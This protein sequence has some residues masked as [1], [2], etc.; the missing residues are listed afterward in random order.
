MS[1]EVFFS[2]ERPLHALPDA[3]QVRAAT[4]QG[5]P[6]LIDR[7]GGNYRQLLNHYGISAEPGGEEEF[8]ELKAL[9]ELLEGC[10]RSLGDPLLGLHL[11]A[12]QEP[13]MFGCATALC[14]AAPSL[15]EA[16]TG[17][18]EFLP[19]I[20]CPELLL[21]LVEGRATTELRWS[22]RSDPGDHRQLDCHGLAIMLKTVRMAAGKAF[23]PDYLLVP[24]DVFRSLAGELEKS[25][26]TQVR[27]GG[28]Q[29]GIAFASSVMDLPVPS[30]N[31]PLYELLL[32]YLR[33]LKMIARKDIIESVSDF[34]YREL[35]FGDASIRSCA[36]SLG[37]S[38]RTLQLR[39]QS[40]GMSFSDILERQRLRRAK[41]ILRNT[42][43]S[44]GD[45]A[46][47]LG[48]GERTS[49]GRAFKRWTG[50]SPQ[51]YRQRGSQH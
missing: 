6:E 36:E 48:Y 35:S 20:H 51:Q 12:V 11:A 49:F 50:L 42:D 28:G 23:Q 2:L 29:A 46:D 47:H 19:V 4:L 24:R 13:D 7:T 18:I 16:I 44:I 9:A 31:G 34:V 43:M 41:S 38:Q 33:R 45:I 15:R 30:A 5:W 8:V 40:R 3:G 1:G 21:E 10:A 17:L 25:L 14:R 22:F 27:T 39:L 26:C 32:G 37:L